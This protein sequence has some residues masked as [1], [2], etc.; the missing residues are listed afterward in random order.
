MLIPVTVTDALP[1]HVALAQDV[2]ADAED[3]IAVRFTALE[4]LTVGGKTVVAKGA[5]VTGSASR[6]GKRRFLGIAGAKLSFELVQVETVDGKKINVRA[7]VARAK[8][9]P[10]VRPF[11]S[12]KGPK[13]KAL[14]AAE[15]AEY[16]AYVDGDQTVS[17]RK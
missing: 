8:N 12:G 10:T 9:G 11:E 4:N 7:A 17:V 15:G 13:N 1:F 3:G 14:A 16:T 2:A 5:T 6:E